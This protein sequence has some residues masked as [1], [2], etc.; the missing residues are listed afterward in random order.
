MRTLLLA[1]ALAS[2]AAG[3]CKEKSD[4]IEPSG[5]PPLPPASGTAVGYLVDAAGD[6]KLSDEQLTK[7]KQIDS[8]LAARN[9]DIDAQLR[10]TEQPEPAE[11]LTPQQMKAGE[12]EK[13]YDNAPGKS[14]MKTSD[15]QKLHKLHDDNE[16]DALKKALAVLDA[17]QLEKAKRILED[18]GVAVPGETQKPDTEAGSDDGTPL[19]GMEP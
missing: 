1:L 4:V 14:T 10:Q 13:R 9:G 3:G 5:P 8:S 11:Q 6:L 7:L 2:A 17:T 15:T 16:R 18:R 12:K 19:P